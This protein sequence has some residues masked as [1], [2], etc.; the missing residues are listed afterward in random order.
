MGTH[1][2]SDQNQEGWSPILKRMQCHFVILWQLSVFFSHFFLWTL[3]NFML[4][5]W[6]KEKTMDFGSPTELGFSSLLLCLFSCAA[7][8]KKLLL[9]QIWH[10]LYTN[11]RDFIWQEV[12]RTSFHLFEVLWNDHLVNFFSLWIN[13]NLLTLTFSCALF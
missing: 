10:H 3:L 8:I 11:H 7:T 6:L 1:P 4:H 13:T 12:W 5:F 9:P 2:I